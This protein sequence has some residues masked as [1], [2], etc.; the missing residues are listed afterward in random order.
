MAVLPQDQ[1]YIFDVK[2]A[3]AVMLE[4]TGVGFKTIDAL[5]VTL[6]IIA[7]K[8]EQAW[9]AMQP[10]MPTRAIQMVTWMAAC[11]AWQALYSDQCAKDWQAMMEDWSKRWDGGNQVH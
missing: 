10:P 2:R 4:V 7:H 11:Y 3:F 8:V 1:K 5:A 9:K 6:A